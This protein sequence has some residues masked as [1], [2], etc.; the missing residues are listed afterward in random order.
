MAKSRS[1]SQQEAAIISKY[2]WTILDIMNNAG[3]GRAWAY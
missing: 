3:T 2:G 1:V